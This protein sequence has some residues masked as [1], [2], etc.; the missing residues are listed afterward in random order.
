MLKTRAELIEAA[1]QALSAVGAGQDAGAEDQALV[2]AR[3]DGILAELAARGVCH[4][5]HADQIP[6][7][8]FEALATIVARHLAKPFALTGPEL[9]DLVALAAD[10]EARLRVMTRKPGIGAMLRVDPALTLRRGGGSCR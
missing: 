3:L 6:A 5:G 9:S 7:A 2:D 8:W 10:A 4:V 1:L